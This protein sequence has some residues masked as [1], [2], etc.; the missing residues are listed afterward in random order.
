M[1]YAISHEPS[2]D[3]G[4]EFGSVLKTRMLIE[5]TTGMHCGC[6]RKIAGGRSRKLSHFY[7]ETKFTRM[8][9]FAVKSR[10]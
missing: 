10:I 5:P 9:D 1:P 3:R 7:D 4:P 8:L 2:G 6:L